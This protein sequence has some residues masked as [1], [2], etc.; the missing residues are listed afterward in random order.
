VRTLI[1]DT[2]T[3]DLIKNK[4]QPL[5]RQPHI[6]EFFGLSMDAEGHECNSLGQLF[7]PGIPL[8]DVTQRITGIKPEDL[9]GKP[10]FAA[11]AAE[12]K[13]FIEGHDEVV[14][15]NLSYDKAMVDFEM[16]RAGIEVEWPELICTV[17]ATEHIKG[18]RLN[19][20]SL[21]ELLMGEAFSGAHR[22]EADVR[23]LANCFRALRE[24]GVV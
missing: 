6:I 11:N 15:H 4:L 5:E 3:T 9:R 18:Y 7:D 10:N 1:F 22:A 20:T 24:T 2:E 19:L 21:H 14:A 16:K 8:S 12:I 17:E 13:K 23:A